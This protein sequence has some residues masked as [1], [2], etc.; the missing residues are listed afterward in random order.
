MVDYPVVTLNQT[1]GPGF[2]PHCE[3]FNIQYR[4]AV[5]AID[6]IVEVNS[7]ASV[8]A[9]LYVEAASLTFPGYC[10]MGTEHGV[11][12]RTGTGPWQIVG[13]EYQ[14]TCA[15]VAGQ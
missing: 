11:K 6:D 2:G 15:I 12:Y 1:I 5:A 10:S 3:S 13:V 8:N 7:T 14:T 9:P 4:W